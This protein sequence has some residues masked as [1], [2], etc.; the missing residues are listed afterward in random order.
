M[1]FQSTI[2]WSKYTFSPEG[3]RAAYF[4]WNYGIVHDHS[5]KKALLNNAMGRGVIVISKN[6]L[7]RWAYVLESPDFSGYLKYYTKKKGLK[8]LKKE[9][10]RVRKD[11]VQFLIQAKWKKSTDKELAKK[12]AWFYDRLEDLV[13][14]APIMRQIDRGIMHVLQGWFAS[15]PR[16][17][18]NIRLLGV[19]KWLSVPVEERLALLRL[20]EKVKRN[21]KLSPNEELKKIHEKFT[22]NTCGY[23]NEKPK[24][25]KEYHMELNEVMKRNPSKEI[26]KI[27]AQRANDLVERKKLVDGLGG[28]DLI[29]TKIAGEAGYLKDYRKFSINEVIYRAEPFFI[30]IAQRLKTTVPMIK[31]SHP[32][33]VFN[34]LIGKKMN[35][36]KV[37]MR[38]HQYVLY[39]FPCKFGMIVGKGAKELEKYICVKKN[40]EREWKGRVASQGYARGTARVVLSQRDFSNVK[41]G[42][43]L[44]VVNT[45]PDFV[46]LM[47]KAAAI[48]AEEGGLTAHVSVVSREFGIPCIVGVEH[49]T[50]RLKDGDLIEVN[51]NNGTIK[52]VTR[53]SS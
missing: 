24:S 22:W 4:Y 2:D 28:E 52:L 11:L 38:N 40:N 35:W 41:K 5:H 18:E 21:P 10:V 1:K 46:S 17:D 26:T 45:G 32:Q 43:I 13:V 53:G 12:S 7:S 42:D 27:M 19:S 20:A 29:I 50:Q 8:E 51:A 36:K 30:E 16:R 15:N 23:Y 37:T 6:H 48:V 34:G 49:I 47:K 31:D 14:P 39:S 25:L 9:I 44:V 33:E 3:G